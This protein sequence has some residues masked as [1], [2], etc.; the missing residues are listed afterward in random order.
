MPP[1]SGSSL[2]RAKAPCRSGWL[3]GW[4]SGWLG[5]LGAIVLALLLAQGEAVRI[6]ALDHTEPDRAETAR[7]H[8]PDAQSG[9]AE[10]RT[11]LS[12]RTPGDR[13]DASTCPLCQNDSAFGQYL[14]SAP[15]A[16]PPAPER[17][18]L[19]APDATAPP[20]AP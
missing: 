7:A 13:H 14:A 5:V 1:A 6:H 20:L 12:H 18:F 17:L 9:R 2:P 8:V 10:A 3:S 4:F 11:T 15:P 16:P 19:A